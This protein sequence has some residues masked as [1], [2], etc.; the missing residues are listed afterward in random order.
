[1]DRPADCGKTKRGNHMNK[2]HLLCIGALTLALTVGLA[3]CGG[4]GAGTAKVPDAVRP[5]KPNFGSQV[6]VHDPSIFKDDDGTYYAFGTHYAVAS[7]TDL[8]SWTQYATDGQWQKL[9]DSAS[10]FTFSGRQWP[11][12]LQETVELV[13]P[14]DTINSTWAPDVIK[15]GNKYYMYYSITSAFG[16]NR[17]AIGRVEADSVTGPYSNNKVLIDSVRGSSNPNAIDPTVFWD[18]DGGLWMVYG[19]AFGGI[20][21]RKLQ[22]SGSNVG[23]IDESFEEIKLWSGSGNNAEG[24]YIFYNAETKYYYLMC[25]YG[26]LSSNYNMRIAR[27][28][29]VTGPY[30]DVSG[31]EVESTPKGGNKLAG[32]YRFEGD[33]VNRALGHNSVLIEGGKYFVV[34]H[35]RNEMGAHHVEVRQLFFNEEGWPLLSPNRYAGEKIGKIAESEFVGDYDLIIHSEDNKEENVASSVYTFAE[36][37]K[38]LEGEDEVGTWKLTGGYYVTFDIDDVTYQGVAVPEWCTYQDRSVISITANSEYGFPVWANHRS[39]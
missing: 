20:C 22:T 15:I 31:N 4:G 17:S 25:S 12:A 7:T 21:L 19:S 5:R 38:L 26:S 13:A 2:K 24:P 37:G 9:Y 28:K 14:D 29:E 36:G 16:S 30:L 18:N 35:V 1:M 3:A 8:I 23:L 10:P 27:S 39:N 6:A 32:N 33:S 11:A 34:C